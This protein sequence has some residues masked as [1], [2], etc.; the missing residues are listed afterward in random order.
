[1]RAP[2]LLSERAFAEAIPLLDSDPKAY[3]NLLAEA[4][5]LNPRNEEANYAYAEVLARFRRENDAVKLVDF[6]Q[7]FAPDPKRQEEALAGIYMIGSRYD[8]SARYAASVLE[9]YPNHLPA[10][11]ILMEALA[12]QGRCEAVDSLRA[13]SASLEKDYPMPPS[14]EF[15][16]SSLD[17]L[18]RTNHEVIFIQRWFGG[19]SLRRRF[20]EKRMS[21]Y[22]Q[23]VQNHDRIRTLKEM[24][25]GRGEAPAEAPAK[26]APKARP[27]M[28]YRGW[29]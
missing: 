9:W 6:I 23:G 4:L 20:V 8:S 19:E 18:F 22:I 26:P 21:A 16:I 11:E 15:T 29:G 1:M 7:K 17:S 3:T 10:M 12:R 14:Q 2:E 25:C 5:R 27:H 13:A 24:R 28:L